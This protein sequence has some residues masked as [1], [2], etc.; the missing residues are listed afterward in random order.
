MSHS[1]SAGGPTIA[2][3][4]LTGTKGDGLVGKVF[5]IGDRAVVGRDSLCDIAIDDPTRTLSRR[6]AEIR[7][8]ERGFVLYD[9]ESRN[10]TH[11]GDVP[12]RKGEG[13]LLGDDVEITLGA[14]YAL[15][16][17]E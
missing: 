10:G 3:A 14:R 11:V 15:Q 13:I 1:P 7:R 9:L 16:F 6:H 2:F 4:N 5:P 12:A 17:S 8:E